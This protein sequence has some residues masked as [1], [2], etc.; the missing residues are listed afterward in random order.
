[1]VCPTPGLLLP[2]AARA[3]EVGVCP[4]VENLGQAR[5]EIQRVARRHAV[6][7]LPQPVTESTIGEG[8]RCPS[9]DGCG[10]LIRMV[11]S[12]GRNP[13][14]EQVAVVRPGV[15]HPADACQP[16]RDIVRVRRRA[17]RCD[18]GQPVPHRVV[19]V[20]EEVGA[21]FVLGG[22]Q[23]VQG[24]VGVRDERASERPPHWA[25]C[26]LPVRL[27]SVDV[28]RAIGGGVDVG[29][30]PQADPIDGAPAV[31]QPIGRGLRCLVDPPGQAARVALPP[32]EF[33]HVR[34]VGDVD[35]RA[36]VPQAGVVADADPQAI[37]AGG[38][39]PQVDLEDSRGATV[40]V[41]DHVVGVVSHGDRVGVQVEAGPIERLNPRH[42]VGHVLGSGG[43]GKGDG[44]A[45]GA[46]RRE[47]GGGRDGNARA[48]APV[49]E[50]TTF[51]VVGEDGVREGGLSADVAL[52][53]GLE[54]VEVLGAGC[55]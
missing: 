38:R 7:G 6:H 3:V 42:T 21:P 43:A 26:A 17:E 11:V 25:D 37:S 52:A 29:D 44:H 8:V 35:P 33:D 9:L 27:E 5:R 22:R 4:I 34:R 49:R 28:E 53:S 50:S 12:V 18:L 2:D 31:V 55:G 23:P 10:Q 1:M 54:G 15:G 36:V 45:L 47:G 40:A 46:G 51:E 20:A 41:E 14:G 24:I 16:V 30:R 19:G 13:I 48:G 39:V 32:V